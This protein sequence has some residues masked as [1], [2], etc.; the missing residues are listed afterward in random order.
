MVVA[1]VVAGRPGS[2]FGGGESGDFGEIVGQNAVAAPDPR[3]GEP[4]E[5][6]AVD[7][8]AVL[9]VADAALTAGSPFDQAPKAGLPLV[10]L[11]TGAGSALAGDGHRAHTGVVQ[12]GL[13]GRF[14]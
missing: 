13:D 6:G 10:G 14:A 5:A 3:P 1:G 7:V 4:I 11:P 12:V 2:G 8:E 9:E